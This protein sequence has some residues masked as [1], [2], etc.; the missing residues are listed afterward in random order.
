MN[1]TKDYQKFK[2][3]DENRKI[4]ES[5]VKAIMESIKKHGF[6]RGKSIIVTMDYEIV[7]GQHRFE[8]LKRLNET[9]EYEIIGGTRQEAIEKVMALNS[10]QSNWRI[11][12]FIESYALTMDCYRKILKFEN[13]FDLGITVAIAYVG[14]KGLKPSQI[15]KGDPFDPNPDHDLMG[16]YLITFKDLYFAR[17]K[18][19]ALAIE[20][21][22]KK[23]NQEQRKRLHDLR[24]KI[25]SSVNV[26]DYL[27]VF[28]NILNQKRRTNRIKLI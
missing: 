9:I 7:D 2:F 13:K 20:T 1:L 12:D 28:E 5:N 26:V 3:L 22:W 17:N 24:L 14:G 19:F 4:N 15:R 21:F 16:N 8:A 10:H 25:P 18:M 6:I 27:T 23:S 11:N